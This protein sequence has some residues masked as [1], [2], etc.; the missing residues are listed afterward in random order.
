MQGGIHCGAGGLT[1]AGRAFRSQ[2][3]TADGCNAAGLT[4]AACTTTEL[5]CAADFT[6]A[7]T[8]VEPTASSA[9]PAPAPA[10][11]TVTTSPV[12]STHSQ[13]T[14]PSPCPIS[15]PNTSC[16]P[17]AIQ[18]SDPP[19]TLSTVLLASPDPDP[20]DLYTAELTSHP[21]AEHV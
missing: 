19:S 1:N 8:T 7:T 15:S 2:A 12:P 9:P 6:L 3:P 18:A 16:P 14:P 21:A 11:V 13:T 4:W 10:P 5:T 20:A 17:G